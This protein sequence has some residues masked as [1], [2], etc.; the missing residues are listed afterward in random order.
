MI[1]NGVATYMYI[2]IAIMMMISMNEYDHVYAH[3]CAIVKMNTY[4]NGFLI[5][6]VTKLRLFLKEIQTCDR[7]IDYVTASIATTAVYSKLILN[8]CQR[9][10]LLSFTCKCRVFRIAIKPHNLVSCCQWTRKLTLCVRGSAL[11]EATSS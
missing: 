11:R 2:Y 7:I 9:V 3:A 1:K 6:S 5:S 10:N 4:T 8:L